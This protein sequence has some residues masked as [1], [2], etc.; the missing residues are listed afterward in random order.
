MG[1]I[2]HLGCKGAYQ[3][4]STLYSHTIAKFTFIFIRDEDPTFF[5]M[6]PDPAEKNPVPDPTLN[7]NEEKNIFIL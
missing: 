3:P 4:C 7:R 6:D 2:S 5:S 1:Q